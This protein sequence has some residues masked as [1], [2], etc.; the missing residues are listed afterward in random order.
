MLGL[1]L[2]FQE[3][4]KCFGTPKMPV[5]IQRSILQIAP[6]TDAR[7]APVVVGT[8]VLATKW[9]QTEPPKAARKVTFK[10]HH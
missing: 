4:A 9:A 5:E 1:P 8:A 6:I 7:C 2:A 3:T 10:G